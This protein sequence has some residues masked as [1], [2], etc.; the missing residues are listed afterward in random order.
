[1][2]LGRRRQ[3]R[4]EELWVATGDLAAAP[5]HVFY[6]R[7]NA[8]LAGAEFDRFVEELCAPF[9][10]DR[11]RPGIPPGVYFRMLFVGYFEGIESQ[12]GIAWRCADSLSLRTFLGM[13]FHE[14]TPD[15]SSMTRIADRL[16]DEVY[17]EVFT[18]VLDVVDAQGLLKGNTVGVDATFLEANAAMKA[19]VR[20]DTGEDWKA[21]LTRLMREEGELDDDEEPTDEDLR[22]FDKK[23]ARQ[24]KKKVSNQDWKSESDEDARIV[25]MKDGRTRLGYKAE[26]VVDLESEAILSARVHHGTESDS[27][28]LVAAVVA[29]QANVIRADCDAEI[30]EVTADKGYHANETLAECAGMGLR[31]YVPEPESPH[32]RVWTDKTDDVQAA[33]L[34][35]R[36]RTRRRKGRRLQRQRSERVERSFAH[37]CDSG[38]TRRSWL[39]GLTKI[40]KRYSIA[41]AAHNLSLVM[42]KLFGMGQPRSAWER[43]LA[44]CTLLAR[45]MRHWGRGLEF[46]AAVLMEPIDRRPR[47]TSTPD[48]P[49]RSRNLNFSTGC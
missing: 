34:N 48:L 38:G 36:R 43:S 19:I 7:L 9:Y 45:L 27:Q 35:N 26:H 10:A 3:E 14:Q 1:M 41:A 2:A 11:G 37:V 32:G 18:F 30:E 22:R 5:G 4:Q 21:Y 44:L 33:V 12:R 24:G 17:A 28:T 6:E 31:T 8:V 25:R 16:P 40:N 46:P 39:R 13:P 15:H 23:R 49:Q 42:R 47:R 20:R 29:A